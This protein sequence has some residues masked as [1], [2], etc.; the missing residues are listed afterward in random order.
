MPES[1]AAAIETRLRSALDPL[2]LEVADDSAR[3]AGHPGAA[4]GGGHYRVHV[5]S[6]RFAGLSRLARHRLVYDVLTDLM[7]H[8]I[9]ALALTAGAPDEQR[10]R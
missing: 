10:C 6:A 4:S 8:D 5:V 9:H 3:H 7:R 1:T 2:V